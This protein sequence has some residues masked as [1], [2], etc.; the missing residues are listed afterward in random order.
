MSWHLDGHKLADDPHKMYVKEADHVPGVDP[1]PQYSLKGYGGISKTTD[2]NYGTVGSGAWTTIDN[3]DSEMVFSPYGVTQD[4]AN[5]GLRVTEQGVYSVSGTL[6]ISFTDTNQGRVFGVRLWNDTKSTAGRQ[7][8]YFVGRNQAGINISQG[9]L[10]VEIGAN[11]VNDL[12][13]MQIAG[14]GS[15]FSD[16]AVV[17]ALFSMTRQG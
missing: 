9:A 6:A 1:H 3:W 16:V 17:D 2:T 15:S 14:A 13:Q 10:L 4:V 5:S 11:E 7:V 12:F 8:D